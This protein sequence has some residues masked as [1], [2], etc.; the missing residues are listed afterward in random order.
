MESSVF[1]FCRLVQG[2]FTP[3]DYV[4]VT[5]VGGIFDLFMGTVT[6]RMG[7]ID[8]PIFSVNATFVTLSVNEP[9]ARNVFALFSQRF[10]MWV[11]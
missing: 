10:R 11:E 2:L 6:D 7:C 9:F 4:T 5:S 3:N 8:L 1:S